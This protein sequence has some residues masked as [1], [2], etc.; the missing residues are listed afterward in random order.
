MNPNPNIGVA[1]E[2]INGVPMDKEKVTLPPTET[3]PDQVVPPSLGTPLSVEPSMVNAPSE[4]IV[5]TTPAP[6]QAEISK[7]HPEPQQQKE[8]K[9]R[10]LIDEVLSDDL[11]KVAKYADQVNSLE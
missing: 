2:N 5:A 10:Q 9:A 1:P 7:V 6:N 3:V 4:V 11:A 8:E